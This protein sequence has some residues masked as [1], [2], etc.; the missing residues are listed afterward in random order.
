M[1]AVTPKL[2]FLGILLLVVV[3]VGFAAFIL[4]ASWFLAEKAGTNPIKDEAYECGMPLLSPARLRFSVKFYLVAV[5]FI[6]FDVEVVFTYPWAVAFDRMAAVDLLADRKVPSFVTWSTV[7]H[8]VLGIWFQ[9]RHPIVEQI[10]KQRSGLTRHFARFGIEGGQ[11]VIVQGRD[12]GFAERGVA[13]AA[14]VPARDEGATT[15]YFLLQ[16]F[17][18]IE[19]NHV[20]FYGGV[21]APVSC[22]LHKHLVK[23]SQQSTSPP[24]CQQAPT[25]LLYLPMKNIEIICSACG[26]DTLLKRE[27]IYEGFAKTGEELTCSA[28]GHVF[29][30]EE[31]VPFKE[32]EAAP[33][34][35]SDADRSES[36]DL[37]EEDENKSLCRYCANYV[38]NPF[39]Q[40]CSAHKKEVQATDSCNQF[41]EK[42]ER[43]PLL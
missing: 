38:I 14:S 8:C 16:L 7:V 1:A 43:K 2:Q 10:G 20:R 28:C 27:P 9:L 36:V 5:L 37:F 15:V 21:I 12:D 6:L 41:E 30:S 23:K 26:E 19:A 13:V 40:F 31:A 22:F 3:A 35:F 25:L 17:D 33:E 11:L 39:M 42:M 4:V 34:I 24:T 18:G 29:E 32:L